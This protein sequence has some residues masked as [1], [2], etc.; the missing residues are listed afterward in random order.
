MAKTFNEIEKMIDLKS[1]D[2]YEYLFSIIPASLKI[3]LL[4]IAKMTDIYLFSGLIRD[5]FLEKRGH[6]D[7]D[8][9]LEKQIDIQDLF[10]DF[11][12]ERN[13]YGGYKI[14]CEDMPIDIWCAKD[15]WAYKF[16]GV[17]DFY[18]GVNIFQT[19][20]FNFSAIIYSL[21]EKKFYYSKNF[22]RFLRDKTIDIVFPVNKNYDLCIINTMYYSAK[23]K[24]KVG[25]KLANEI[26]KYYRNEPHDFEGVQKKHFGEIKYDQH[27]IEEFIKNKKFLTPAST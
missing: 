1:I 13:S 19:A 20:Y 11:P 25:K 5:Y 22:L 6:R 10:L 18:I 4:N 14:L 24:L 15:T 17:F 8:I 3:I 27:A 23:Y 12:I 26:T 2:F 16:Q 9:V 21:N 7:I